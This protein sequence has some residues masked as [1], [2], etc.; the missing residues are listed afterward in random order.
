MS[1]IRPIAPALETTS[2]RKNDSWRISASV[3]S[4]SSPEPLALSESA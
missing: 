2:A 1:C 4:G 3:S